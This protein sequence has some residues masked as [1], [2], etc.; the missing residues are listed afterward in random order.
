MISLPDCWSDALS[1]GCFYLKVGKL[2][3]F[4]IQNNLLVLLFRC[5]S[6]ILELDCR[7]TWLWTVSKALIHAY[8]PAKHSNFEY[9]HFQNATQDSQERSLFECPKEPSVLEKSISLVKLQTQWSICACKSCN[10][11]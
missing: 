6:L 9:F 11:A 4:G 1:E 3:T 2:I 7:S 5:F 8:F 10:A